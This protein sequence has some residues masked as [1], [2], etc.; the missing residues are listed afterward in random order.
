MSDFDYDEIDR[1]INDILN[2]EDE[3]PA[4][5]PAPKVV[6][7]PTPSSKPVV[8][9]SP[10]PRPTPAPQP[11]VAQVAPKPAP[12]PIARPS[13][14]RPKQT[15][16]HPDISD[17]RPSAAKNLSPAKTLA[18]PTK[19][20]STVPGKYIDIIAASPRPL[21]KIDSIKSVET[22]TTIEQDPISTLVTEEILATVATPIVESKSA[23]ELRAEAEF[24]AEPQPLDVP[25]ITPVV[26]TASLKMEPKPFI[27][28]LKVEKRP[29]S[30]DLPSDHTDTIESTRN[31]Y[32]RAPV[33]AATTDVKK[34]V[35]QRKQRVKK[36]KTPKTPKA[37]KDKSEKFDLGFAFIII[38]IIVLGAAAGFL[39]F[40]LIAN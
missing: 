11:Q 2:E 25:D 5:S 23:A 28:N 1:A 22:R 7:K 32:S 30:R 27:D 39:L 3:T 31:T 13:V 8:I 9:P 26:S 10:A 36:V 20:P 33:S 37:P 16:F 38:V 21:R 15:A 29:L 35:K 34:P 14:P 17:P 6:A 40:L 18:P 12:K 24:V 19:K 4:P